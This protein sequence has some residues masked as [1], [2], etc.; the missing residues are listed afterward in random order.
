MKNIHEIENKIKDL[1]SYICSDYCNNPSDI[2]REINK[3]EKIIIEIKNK[4]Q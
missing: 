4:E 1:K 2:Y 3:L